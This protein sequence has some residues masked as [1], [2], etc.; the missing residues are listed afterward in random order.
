MRVVRY[1]FRNILLF[2][3]SAAVGQILTVGILAL[4]I[5]GA[6]SLPTS[7]LFFATCA[8]AVAVSL[9]GQFGRHYY[10][11]R[12]EPYRIR[13]QSM[14]L[15]LSDGGR[16]IRYI[17]KFKVRARHSEV[18]QVTR[19]LGWTGATDICALVRR[20]GSGYQVA[21]RHQTNHRGIET[22]LVVVDVTLD[23]PL[24]RF[25]SLVF[26]L[27]VDIREEQLD[28]WMHQIG[29]NAARDAHSL[30]SSLRLEVKWDESLAPLWD[31]VVWEEFRTASDIDRRRHPMHL[32]RGEKLKSRRD[33][34]LLGVRVQPDTS[35][36]YHRLCF[37]FHEVQTT[38]V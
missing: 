25:H 33:P 17:A 38:P 32:R 24:R 21:G 27:E 13:S 4:L 23:T 15:Q 29:Y 7:R 36:S 16:K 9:V 11:D 22:G 19:T 28:R 20:G 1:V 30:F 37:Q 3:T 35:M 6:I 26:S 5:G 12:H 31:D 2:V 18:T 8:A 14:T 34:R 10:E